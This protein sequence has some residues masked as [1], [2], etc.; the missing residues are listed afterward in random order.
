MPRNGD[1]YI[2]WN[3]KMPQEYYP[4]AEKE[5]EDAV[6]KYMADNRKNVSVYK[7]KTDYVEIEQR[8]YTLTLGQRI[9]LISD[10]YFPKT[11]YRISRITKITRKVNRPT[12]MDIEVSDV[13]SKSTFSSI[14]DSVADTKSYVKTLTSSLPGIIKS[15][16]N[17]PPSDYN[18][19]SSKK[20]DKEIAKKSLSRLYDDN[21][22]GHMTF[23]NGIT[24]KS[25]MTAKVHD[26]RG[27]NRTGRP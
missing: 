22:A 19:Y 17:T 12:E 1:K 25:E 11:G 10:K 21:T 9:K 3:I 26:L 24:V 13:L 6:I 5:Y 14:S 8:N 20:V 16:E 2:L 27:F 23:E 7:G 18:L 15:W 4:L